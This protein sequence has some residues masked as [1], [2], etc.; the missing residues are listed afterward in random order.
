MSDLVG[1]PK[2]QFSLV[3][4]H[5]IYHHSGEGERGGI[6]IEHWT[7]SRGLVLCS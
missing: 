7:E 5:L 1:N 6:V 4:A 3:A 2:D